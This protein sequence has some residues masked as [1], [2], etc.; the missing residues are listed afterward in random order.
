[1]DNL[2]ITIPK[3]LANLQLPD[4]VLLQEYSDSDRRIIWIDYEIDG[5]LLSV[6]KKILQWNY[7]DIGLAKEERIPIRILLFSPG[8]DL[9]AALQCINVIE[10]SE[11]PVYGFNMGEASSA[12]LLILLACSKRFCL[13]DSTACLHKGGGVFGGIASQIENSVAYYKN[14]LAKMKDYVLSHTTIDARTYKKKQDEDWFFDSDDQVKY[15]LVDKVVD[16][17][18]IIIGGG[19]LI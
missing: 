8:G 14:Q 3:D 9:Y 15:G 5:F 6:T 16:N 17:I 13:K 4:P 10:I 7:E 12:A 1:M 11:T 19:D 18:D 2:Q